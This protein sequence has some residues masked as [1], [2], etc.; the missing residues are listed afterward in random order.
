MRADVPI[1]LNIQEQPNID[2]QFIIIN[3]WLRYCISN[4]PNCSQVKFTSSS[5]RISDVGQ[6]SSRLLIT[7]PASHTGPYMALSH[8]WGAHQPLITTKATI[9]ERLNGLEFNSLPKN[10]KGAIIV[11]RR[12]R[13][14]YLWIDSLCIVQ[15]DSEDWTREA[16]LMGYVYANSYCTIAATRGKSCQDGVLSARYGYNPATLVDESGLN[17]PCSMQACLMSWNLTCRWAIKYKGLG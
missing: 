12:L 13:I 14:Q 7:N 15:D 6:D 8:C 5:T 17:H 3:E 10:F 1:G 11:T 9:H 16:T 2:V 4:H